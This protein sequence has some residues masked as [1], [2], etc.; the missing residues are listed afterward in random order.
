MSIRLK[1]QDVRELEEGARRAAIAGGMSCMA[2]YGEA[3]SRLALVTAARN[4]ATTADL[5]ATEHIL[6][7]LTATMLP[8]AAR[9]GRGVSF[10]AEELLEGRD[11][12]VQ[13]RLADI[14]KRLPMASLYMKGS[15]EEFLESLDHGIGVLFDALDG[16]TNFRAGLPLFCTAVAVF[17]EGRPRVGAIFDPMH[18]LV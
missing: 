18:N 2:F 9:L 5:E 17:L 4:A 1:L 14:R 8:V 12:D 11:E 6:A 16:T 13:R 10:F 7:S 15:S 3:I